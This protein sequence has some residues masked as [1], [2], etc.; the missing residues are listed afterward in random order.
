MQCLKLVSL[1]LTLCASALLIPHAE[2][3]CTSP[4]IPYDVSVPEIRVSNSLT[5]GSI[6]PGTEQNIDVEGNC[7]DNRAGMPIVACYYGSGNEIAGYPG[8]YKTGIAGIGIT[9]I[10]QQG[11]RVRGGGTQCDTRSTPLGYV[12]SD[13]NNTFNFNVA[14][15]LVKTSTNVTSGTLQQSETRFG[16]GVYGHEG[17]GTPNTVSYAGTVNVLQVTCAVSPQSLN[18]TLG[19][20]PVSDFT[21][22]G[23]TTSEKGFDVNITCDDTVQPEVMLSSANGYESSYPGVIKL[24]PENGAATGVGIEM[25]FDGMVATFDQYKTTA[26]LAYINQT[27]QIPFTARYYQTTDTVTPG[28]ANGVATLTIGYK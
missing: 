18:I 11:Q 15:A 1:L 23:A 27:L 9:L 20:F 12:S 13:G 14:L 21:H 26:S 28:T 25:M 6:I 5:P 10:N 24:T 19:D 16:I 2:A 3:A 8:V 22:I 17:I 7:N 4:T